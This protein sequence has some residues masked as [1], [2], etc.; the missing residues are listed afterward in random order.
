[1]GAVDI[2]TLGLAGWGADVRIFERARIQHPGGVTVASHVL[3]DD[4]VVIDGAGGVRIGSYVHITAFTSITGGGPCVLG[5]FV[6]LSSGVR[7]LTR[8]AAADGDREGVV[9]E[10]HAFVGANAVVEPGVRIGE[11]A[12]LGSL[13]VADADL[14]PWTVYV[15]APARAVRERPRERVLAAGREALSRS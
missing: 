8:S 12:V 10:D 14:E 7:L 13:S 5:D 4:F 3:I 15:G 11:G 2:G 1:V 9:L 6:G